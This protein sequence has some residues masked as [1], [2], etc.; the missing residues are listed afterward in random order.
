MAANKRFVFMSFFG[1]IIGNSEYPPK[2]VNAIVFK[3]L[4]FPTALT[5]FYSVLFR[6]PLS[7]ISGLNYFK[8][9][10]ELQFQEQIFL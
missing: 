7:K 10:R 5:L 9:F 4:F 3:F 6:F 1:A 2:N 8:E